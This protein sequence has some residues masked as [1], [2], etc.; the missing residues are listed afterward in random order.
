MSLYYTLG[1]VVEI[2]RFYRSLVSGERVRV[3]VRGEGS[4]R[5][6]GEWGRSWVRG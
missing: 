1:I 5:K 3:W 4:F 6:V 2:L